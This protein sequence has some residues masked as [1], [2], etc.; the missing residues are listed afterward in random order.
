MSLH[1][2]KS[3]YGVTT[4]SISSYPLYPLVETMEQATMVRVIRVSGECRIVPSASLLV[5]SFYF[6]T[7]F[8]G[9]LKNQFQ[10]QLVVKY[11]DKADSPLQSIE[12]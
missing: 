6:L 12:K 9:E 4:H 3:L 10:R 11:S 2:P 8:I 1:W 5:I 7:E